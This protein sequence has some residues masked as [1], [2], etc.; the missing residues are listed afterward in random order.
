MPDIDL[1][2]FQSFVTPSNWVTLPYSGPRGR[3][4][5]IRGRVITTVSGMR[6]SGT[7]T[8]MVRMHVASGSILRRRTMND[9]PAVP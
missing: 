2:S 9:A 8:W 3:V 7:L 4:L 1:S 5:M 6:H